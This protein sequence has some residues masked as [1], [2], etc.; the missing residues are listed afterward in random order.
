MA[1]PQ[2]EIQTTAAVALPPEGRQ[3]YHSPDAER[4]AYQQRMARVFVASGLFSDIK[5]QSPEQA[6]AQAYVKIALGGSMGF[7]EA[8]SMQGIDII[9]GR[10]A[11][12][13]Q[14]RAARMQRAGFSW[15]PT[16]TEKGCWLALFFNRAPIMVPRVNPATSELARDKDGTIIQEQAIVSYTMEDAK[17][18]KLADKDNWK[19][20]P[21]SMLFA[22]AITRAQRRFAPGVLSGDILTREEAFDAEP[23]GFGPVELKVPQ[24]LPADLS[25]SDAP[26]FDASKEP[27]QAAETKPDAPAE[28]KPEPKPD[29][30]RQQMLDQLAKIEANLGQAEFYRRLGGGGYEKPEDIPA[31]KLAAAIKAIQQD[32]W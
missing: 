18:A 5:G 13:A 22:R 24:A 30:A 4:F 32:K 14:L 6:M 16:V 9:Q 25:H 28:G 15:A 20:D 27:Q 1:T 23:D 7:S 12:S 2:T 17:S 8:E 3:L 29:P 19:K 26:T 11:I 31:N 10:P 21:S